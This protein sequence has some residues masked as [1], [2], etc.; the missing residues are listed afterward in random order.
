MLMSLL[1]R[2]IEDTDKEFNKIEESYGRW[3]NDW[4][5]RRMYHVEKEREY[6]LEVIILCC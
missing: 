6:A 3:I 1:K 2:V 5:T 4:H